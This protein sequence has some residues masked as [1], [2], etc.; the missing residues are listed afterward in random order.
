MTLAFRRIKVYLRIGLIL[1]VAFVLGLVVWKNRSHEVEFWFFGIPDG[2]RPINVLWLMLCT[3]A[4]T[5]ISWW[6]L[7]FGRGLR[8]AAFIQFEED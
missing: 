2:G 3:A 8:R 6:L 4:G 5:L 7:S 1:I